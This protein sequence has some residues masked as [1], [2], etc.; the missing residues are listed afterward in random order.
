MG[1]V[2]KNMKWTQKETMLLQDMV[3]AEEVCIEKYADYADRACDEELKTLF[4]SIRDA[5]QQHYDT[6]TQMQG[7]TIPKMNAG[8][9]QKQQNSGESCEACSESTE[10]CEEDEYLCRDALDS[11][12]HVSSLYDTCIFEFV[13][14]DARNVLNHIQKEEQE[15]GKRIYDYMAAHGMT[16]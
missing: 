10:V 8:G 4:E 9:P 5:E 14:A 11:E 13:S 1:E 6:L 15:H 7:G 2:M 3:S 16:A 12:K